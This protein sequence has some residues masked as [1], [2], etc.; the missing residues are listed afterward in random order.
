MVSCSCTKWI[1]NPC[2][3]TSFCI[4]YNLSPT[5]P[6]NDITQRPKIDLGPNLVNF[7]LKDDFGK[8]NM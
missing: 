8:E 2:V 5:F 4:P 1:S 6:N 3:D 7:Y